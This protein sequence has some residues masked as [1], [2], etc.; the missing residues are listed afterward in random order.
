MPPPILATVLT[1]DITGAALP[2][3]PRGACASA[4][5]LQIDCS[6]EGDGLQLLVSVCLP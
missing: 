3:P 2:P 1:V 5:R 6:I 4:F